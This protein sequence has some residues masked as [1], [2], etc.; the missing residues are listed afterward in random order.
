MAVVGE[1]NNFALK[2]R[3]MFACAFGSSVVYSSFNVCSFIFFVVRCRQKS[4]EGVRRG[5]SRGEPLLV[6]SA[7]LPG[8]F[9][10]S[11]WYGCY[12]NLWA[13]DSF[14][15]LF[16]S[17][18]ALA[19]FSRFSKFGHTCESSHTHSNISERQK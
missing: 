6:A 1:M 9:G 13:L 11:A 10:A 4:K 17:R 2:N 3:M 15:I 16:A 18:A 12:P 19:K 14:A 7:A 5:H 8:G